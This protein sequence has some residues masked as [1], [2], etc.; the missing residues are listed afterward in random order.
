MMNISPGQSLGT[1]LEVAMHGREIARD[2]EDL[3][4]AQMQVRDIIGGA[5]EGILPD[6][7]IDTLRNAIPSLQPATGLQVVGDPTQYAQQQAQGGTAELAWSNDQGEIL[8]LNKIETQVLRTLAIIADIRQR[9]SSQAGEPFEDF[10]KKRK[11]AEKARDLL[12]K[13]LRHLGQKGL[14]KPETILDRKNFDE[15]LKALDGLSSE[16]QEE[17][18]TCWE[19]IQNARNDIVEANKIPSEKRL[20]EIIQLHTDLQQTL[21]DAITRMSQ[22]SSEQYDKALVSL[23]LMLESRLSTMRMELQKAGLILVSFTS[24]VDELSRLLDQHYPLRFERPQNQEVRHT[25]DSLPANLSEKPAPSSTLRLS[26]LALLIMMSVIIA[27]T[28]TSRS[29]QEP[30]SGPK[31]PSPSPAKPNIPLP[32]ETGT[33]KPAVPETPG[34]GIPR[35]HVSRHHNRKGQVQYLEIKELSGEKREFEVQYFRNADFGTFE[36]TRQGNRMIKTRIFISTMGR[37]GAYTVEDSS[38]RVHHAS[39]R[40]LERIDR[41]DVWGAVELQNVTVLNEISRIEE[42]R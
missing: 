4:N 16:D 18:L 10:R 37:F 33:K 39:Q 3:R 9:I 5:L 2:H 42:R 7:D 38:G 24:E 34:F 14:Q 28:T 20:G 40:I 6:E 17:L 25:T 12:A 1:T 11:R 15:R 23:Q 30:N 13:S 29:P 8:E 22:G 41:G 27:V 31:T 19:R 21:Q 35:L 26:A 36:V 32:K